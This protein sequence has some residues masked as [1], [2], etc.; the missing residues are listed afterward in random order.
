MRAPPFRPD[1][2]QTPIGEFFLDAAE[3]ARIFGVSV[4]T[5]RRWDRRGRIPGKVKSPGR[6]VR[7]KRADV[8]AWLENGCRR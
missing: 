4:R 1:S 5:V 2:Q 6:A 7:W 8:L 3:I